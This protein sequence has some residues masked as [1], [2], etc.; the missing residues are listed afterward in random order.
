LADTVEGGKGL[1]N[2]TNDRAILQNRSAL[3]WWPH[4]LFLDDAD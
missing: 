1:Q 3:W 2:E 4:R